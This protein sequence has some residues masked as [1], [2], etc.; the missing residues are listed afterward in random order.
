M[1]MLNCYA[2]EIQAVGAYYRFYVSYV[3]VYEENVC[4]NGEAGSEEEADQSKV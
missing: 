1:E 2:G 3:N 4:V